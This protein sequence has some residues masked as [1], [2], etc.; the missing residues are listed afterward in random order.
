MATQH[1]DNAE[2]AFWLGKSFI[3]SKE[4]VKECLVSFSELGCEEFMWD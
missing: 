4:E 2:E 1:L 3:D